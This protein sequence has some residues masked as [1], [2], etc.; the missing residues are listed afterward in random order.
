MEMEKLCRTRG[1]GFL[2]A[3]F[4]NGLGYGIRPEI[5]ER[6]H[7]S[8]ETSG[9]ALVDMGARFRSMGLRAAQLSIDSTGHLGPRGHALTSEI[10]EQEL[11][12]RFGKGV[13]PLD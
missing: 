8:L 5:S 6:F 1:I 11:V 2:V 7:R 3:T 12:N 4:P 13:R 9:V 10:L